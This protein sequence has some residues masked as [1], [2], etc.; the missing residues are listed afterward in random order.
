MVLVA[1]WHVGSSQIRDWTR[2]SCIGRQVLYHWAT[3]EA[4]GKLPLTWR[5]PPPVDPGQRLLMTCG[6]STVVFSRL[7][8]CAGRRLPLRQH[9]CLELGAA[10][11]WLP[12]LPYFWE[13]KLHKSH[14]LNLCLLSAWEESD[15][16]C[17]TKLGRKI[18]EYSFHYIHLSG[19][20]TKSES[21][22]I[23]TSG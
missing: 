7:Q 16:R 19:K 14:T 11:S 22:V 3:R 17:S 1:P 6:P 18:Q 4:P 2:V 23:Q 13:H 8:G 21:M 15:L 5:S 9:L 20:I 12:W 10:L